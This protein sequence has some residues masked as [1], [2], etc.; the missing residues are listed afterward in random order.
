MKIDLADI[1]IF[2][3]VVAICVGLYHFSGWA[4]VIFAGAALIA[5]GHILGRAAA[6][7]QTR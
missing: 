2:V 6:R 7:K 4:V 1:F 3:G 5:F